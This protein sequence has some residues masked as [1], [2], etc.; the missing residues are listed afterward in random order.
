MLPCQDTPSTK[1]TYSAKVCL[2]IKNCIVYKNIYFIKCIDGLIMDN[3]QITA[4]KPLTALMS[5][6]PLDVIDY[7]ETRTFLFQQ[8]V[9]V[10]SYL[11]ALAIGNLV[12]KTLSPI[13]KVWSEPEEIDKAAYEFEQV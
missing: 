2:I 5:A 10:Q 9:P 8:T 3:L 1:F 13:S 11:I 6:V 12:S 4:P 7:G